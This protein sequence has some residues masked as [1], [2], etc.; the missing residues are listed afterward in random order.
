MSIF[1]HIS[2]RLPPVDVRISLAVNMLRRLPRFSYRLP[3]EYAPSART[4][5]ESAL[6]SFLLPGLR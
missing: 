3:H 4:L 5:A 6:K 2:F 1:F